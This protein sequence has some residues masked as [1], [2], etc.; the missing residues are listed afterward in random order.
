MARLLINQLVALGL[1]PAGYFI[2]VDVVTDRIIQN[3]DKI[4]TSRPTCLT[5]ISRVKRVPIELITYSMVGYYPFEIRRSTHVRSPFTAILCSKIKS[6]IEYIHCLTHKSTGHLIGI[7]SWEGKVAEGYP[8]S[9]PSILH[10]AEDSIYFEATSLY[11]LLA[12][13]WTR[14]PLPSLHSKVTSM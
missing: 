14:F 7:G 11:T 4:E 13:A 10:S 6:F 9:K 5:H 12:D 1:T 2:L 8:I 3:W